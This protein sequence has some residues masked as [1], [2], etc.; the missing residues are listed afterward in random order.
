MNYKMNAGPGAYAV[1]GSPLSTVTTRGA[2]SWQF[3]AFV[4]G[5]TLAFVL[6]IVDSVVSM[7]ATAHPKAPAYGLAAKLLLSAA[8]AYFVLFNLRVRNGLVGYLGAWKKENRH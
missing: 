7:S 1:D 6:S 3:F 4:F 2:E 8:D 5:A